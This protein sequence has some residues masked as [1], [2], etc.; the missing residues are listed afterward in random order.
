VVD[1]ED[2]ESCTCLF[3]NDLLTVNVIPGYSNTR[4]A[5]GRDEAG[6]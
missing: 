6:D 3:M 4:G 5:I 2:A 1:F